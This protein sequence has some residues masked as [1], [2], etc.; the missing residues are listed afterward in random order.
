MRNVKVLLAGLLLSGCAA[1]L[2]SG[3]A[4][5]PDFK[6]PAPPEAGSYTP[7]PL[8]GAVATP[9]VTGGEAQHFSNGGDI[10]GDWWTLFHSPAL[11]SLIAQALKNNSDLKAAA[12]ALRSAHQTALAGSGGFFPNIALAANASHFEQPAQT[13]AP[14][15][16]NNAFQYDL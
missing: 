1:G 10:A 3:C 4:V 8:T 7:T 12:A 2:L 13:L 5:G 15:P 11:D 6:K 16:A 14:V 9:G